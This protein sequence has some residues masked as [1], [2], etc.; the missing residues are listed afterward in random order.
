MLTIHERE[1]AA[2]ISGNPQAALLA[3]LLD[4]DDDKASAER[5]TEEA[6]GE[7]DAAERERERDR[8]V[9]NVEELLVALA[10][11]FYS[12]REHTDAERTEIGDLL[13]GVDVHSTFA[14]VKRL[15]A[16]A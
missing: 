3:E 6:Q 12:S 10:D 7:A 13:T 14:A 11:L 5:A 8:L 9:E 1:R 16:L 2:Y 4:A 15:R